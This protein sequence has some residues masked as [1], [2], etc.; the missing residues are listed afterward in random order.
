MCA[1]LLSNLATRGLHVPESRDLLAV[2]DGSDALRS[3]LLSQFPTAQ[4]QRCLALLR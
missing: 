1:D 4:V 2:L 3:A